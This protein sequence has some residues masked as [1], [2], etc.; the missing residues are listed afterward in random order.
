MQL[1]RSVDI[2]GHVGDRLERLDR[3]IMFAELYRYVP[4]VF[5]DLDEKEQVQHHPTKKNNF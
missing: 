4:E 1:N 5:R 3:A 2:H